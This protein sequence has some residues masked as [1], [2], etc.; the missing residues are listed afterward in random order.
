MNSRAGVAVGCACLGIL[1]VTGPAVVAQMTMQPT[2]PPIVTADNEAW[3]QAGVPITHAGNTYYPTGPLVHFNGNEMVRSGHFEAVPLYA[4]TTI[5]PYSMVFVPLKGGLM[6][7]YER[8]RSGEL[9][10]S[11][12]SA[13]P[14]FPVVRAAEQAGME[15][16]PGA[17]MIQAPAPPSLSALVEPAAGSSAGPS[18]AIGTAGA[19]VTFT[20]GP[21]VTAQRPQGLNGVFVEYD[22]QRYFA[23]GPAV[24]FSEKTFTRVGEY[25]GFPVFRQRGDTKTL[26][27]PPLRGTPTIVAPYRLR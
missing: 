5:E 4:R 1:L 2:P 21:L 8:R 12:G 27:L 14:S 15:Y 22:G 17:G 18:A 20:R 7:P 3:Y 6:Q 19:D 26:Y 11:V 23:D 9:A 25:Y 24:S 16:V 10:D 13:T